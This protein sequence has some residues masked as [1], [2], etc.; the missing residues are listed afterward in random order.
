MYPI[1]LN[2]QSKSVLIVGGGAVASRKAPPLLI[3]GAKLS[4]ISPEITDSLNALVE[5]GQIHWY[6]QAYESSLLIT[7]KP[8]LVFAAT[9][10][11]TVNQQ[12]AQDAQ[13][14]SAWVNHVADTGASDFQN[15]AILEKA[16]FTIAMNSAG[17]SPALLG[18][19]KSRLA[20]VLTDGFVTFA[21]WLG[22]LRP[23]A[24]T[25]L[26]EQAQRQALYERLIQSDVLNLLEKGQADLARQ[27]FERI[28]ED[29][30]S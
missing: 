16:P 30:F 28:V 20:T 29:S 10:S 18:I 27:E 23:Q 6:K 13:A 1:A 2:L 21:N 17:A 12:I 8:I 3:A 4:I 24:Q 7:L 9:S 22:A 15:M 26:A 11:Q 25:H 14:L 19:L 5:Q